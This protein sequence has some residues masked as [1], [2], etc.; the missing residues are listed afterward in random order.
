M[1]PVYLAVIGFSALQLGELTLVVGIG[2]AILSTSIGL[3]SD[4]LGRK[5]FLIGVPLLAAAAGLVFAFTRTPAWL[6]LAD[7]IGRFGR[8]AGAGAGTVGPYQPVEQALVTETISPARRNVAFGRLAFASSVGAL[9]GGPLAPPAAR[10][11]MPL[12][13]RLWATNSVNG[14]AVGLFGPFVTYWFFRRYG[15]GAGQIGLLFGV[16]NAATAASTLSAA[17]IARRW[18]LGRT[19]T[20]ARIAQA[21]LL[22]PMSWHPRSCSRGRSTSCAWSCS[23]SRCRCTSHTCS[24]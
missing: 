14:L 17:R 5:P 18:G 20:V 2:A 6:F 22:V 24:R 9:V 3:V 21:M 23:G 16:I 1:T 8:G 19:V 7:A 13:M 12:L 15:V 4:R 10:R 11:S